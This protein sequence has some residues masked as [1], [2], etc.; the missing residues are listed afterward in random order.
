[1]ENM[2]VIASQLTDDSTEAPEVDVANIYLQ[3]VGV[4]RK[5]QRVY[6]LGTHASSF[7]LDSISSSSSASSRYSTLFDERLREELQGI[8]DNLQRK[9][10]EIQ[11]KNEEMQK[12]IEDMKKREEERVKR[13]EEMQQKIEEMERL[14]RMF[15]QGSSAS[16]PSTSDPSKSP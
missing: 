9:N 12:Q 11:Q 15:T 6:G 14:V 16:Q 1:M 3:A 5:R 4:E 10:E 7:Y 2:V 13:E 8:E